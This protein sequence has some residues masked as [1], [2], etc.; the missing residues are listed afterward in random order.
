MRLL[1]IIRVA[2]PVSALCEG[3]KSEVDFAVKHGTVLL[4]LISGWSV[5]NFFLKL[6]QNKRKEWLIMRL[7]ELF[8]AASGTDPPLLFVTCDSITAFDIKDYE[9]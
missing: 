1:R 2:V 8:G 7:L 3:E 4:Q 6:Q 9:D 5:I